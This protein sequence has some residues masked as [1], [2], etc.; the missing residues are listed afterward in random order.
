MDLPRVAYCN[1]DRRGDSFRS[2]A[3]GLCLEAAFNLSVWKLRREMDA[4]AWL[5]TVEVIAALVS[6][7]LTL[8]DSPLRLGIS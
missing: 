1:H 5:E 3:M 8:H 2:R 7:A 6:C 4:N